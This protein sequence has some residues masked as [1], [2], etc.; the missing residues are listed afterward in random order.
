MALS[1]RRVRLPGSEERAVREEGLPSPPRPP[2]RTPQGPLRKSRA[3]QKNRNVQRSPEDGVVQKN[4][5]VQ[6]GGPVQKGGDRGVQYVEQTVYKPQWVTETGKVTCTEY[7]QEQR[8]EQVTVNV[9][10]PITENV[11]RQYTAYVPMYETKETTCTVQVPEWVDEQRTVTVMVP[12]TE[13][14][15]GTAGSARRSARP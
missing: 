7:R 6:K 9:C 13:Q 14:R 1:G 10:V 11:E 3:V 2:Q 5:V 8:T 4:G 15:Q 12:Y